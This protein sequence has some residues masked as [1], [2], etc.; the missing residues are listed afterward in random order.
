MMYV[1][2][3]FPN[4]GGVSIVNSCWLTPLKREV[5][6][7]PKQTGK[8]FKKL[9]Q[10]LEDPPQDGTWKVHQIHRIFFETSKN[11]IINIHNHSVISLFLCF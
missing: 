11:L 7:P 1:G 8:N 2:V 4:N 3:E 6:W 9:L 5:Y 10:T